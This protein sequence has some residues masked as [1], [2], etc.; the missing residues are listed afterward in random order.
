MD[1][2]WHDWLMSRKTKYSNR[3]M[4]ANVES[5]IVDGGGGGTWW[6]RG[7]GVSEGVRYR[8][9][10]IFK[11]VNRYIMLYKKQSIVVVASYL[12]P[13]NQ[14][15]NPTR[16]PSVCLMLTLFICYSTHSLNAWKPLQSNYAFL[17]IFHIRASKKTNL[18][19]KKVVVVPIE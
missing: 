5:V 17:I 12:C 1:G 8:D 3:A 2:G 18:P 4:R 15:I 9:D 6:V 14:S 7:L 16:S 11:R 19:P 10:P 13:Y